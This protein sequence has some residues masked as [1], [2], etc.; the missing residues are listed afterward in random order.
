VAETVRLWE[1]LSGI[2]VR[3]LLPYGRGYIVN[4]TY[5]IYQVGGDIHESKWQGRSPARSR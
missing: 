4:G 2:K 1:E 3:E 5:Y